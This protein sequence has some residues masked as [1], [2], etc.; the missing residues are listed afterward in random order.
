MIW[1]SCGVIRIQRSAFR[2]KICRSAGG[3]E[4]HRSRTLGTGE[5]RVGPNPEPGP[6]LR[7]LVRCGCACAK[8]QDEARIDNVMIIFTK[9][10]FRPTGCLYPQRAAHP[11][12]RRPHN[13][14]DRFLPPHLA[15]S[16][17][18]SVT[19]DDELRLSPP[20]WQLQ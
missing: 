9:L 6:S 4:D 16:P 15:R 20:S 17:T 7:P 18:I 8:A 3:S 10:A 1:R 11:D 5:R 13:L 14:G 2:W 12:L 19:T